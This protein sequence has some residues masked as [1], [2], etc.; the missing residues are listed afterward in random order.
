MADG[1]YKDIDVPEGFMFDVNGKQVPISGLVPGT[2][3]TATIATTTTPAGAGH[4]GEERL[5]REG[6]WS[7][8]RHQ[9]P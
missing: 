7:D 1:Q 6:L 2:E 4:R 8:G 5:R 9:D 3:L